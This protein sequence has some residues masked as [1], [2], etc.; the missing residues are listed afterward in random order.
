MAKAVW[1]AAWA[2][3]ASVQAQTVSGV[4]LE[5]AQAKVGE[6]VKITV[7]FE[8]TELSNCALRVHFGD[9]QVQKYTVSKASDMPLVITRAYDKPGQYRIDVEPTTAGITLK[10]LGRRT[11]VMLNVAAVPSPTPTVSSAVTPSS[12]VRPTATTAPATVTASAPTAASTATTTAAVPSKTALCPEGWTLAKPGQNAK[13]K[14]FTCSAKV[15]TKIPE[16]R[17]NCPGDLTYF[18]NSKRGQLGCRV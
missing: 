14:A 6:P 3:A 11:Q 13:T 4:K 9:G 7:S 2:L 5:P 8:P 10:C 1:I 18:E 15:G 17:L 16:P 12:S